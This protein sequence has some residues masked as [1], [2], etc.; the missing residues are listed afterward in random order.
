MPPHPFIDSGGASRPAGSRCSLTASIS[1]RIF[2]N[3]GDDE[4]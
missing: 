1:G 4:R 2:Y 3:Q